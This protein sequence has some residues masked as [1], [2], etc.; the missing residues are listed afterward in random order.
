MADVSMTQMTCGECF[1]VFCVPTTFYEDRKQGTSGLRSFSCPA[2]HSRRFAN[3]TKFE[4]ER[5][6]RQRA[7]QENARLAE[8]AYAAERARQRAETALKNHKRRSA[9]GTCPCCKRTFANMRTHMMSKHPEFVADSIA[10]LD[11]RK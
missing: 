2:G 5:R 6:L 10:K 9:A 8:E 1:M 4:T 7:E 11:A 3:E